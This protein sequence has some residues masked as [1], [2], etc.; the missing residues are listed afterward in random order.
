LNQKK[1]KTSEY[2]KIMFIKKDRDDFKE[3]K[4]YLKSLI[5]AIIIIFIL[6]QLEIAGHIDVVLPSFFSFVLLFALLWGFFSL[7]M[8]V[9]IL[10]EKFFS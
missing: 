3:L 6:V 4:Y 8:I 1:R 7:M 10:Y 9:V 5:M 2:I